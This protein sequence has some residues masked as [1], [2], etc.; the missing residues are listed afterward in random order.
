MIQSGDINFGV[1]NTFETDLNLPGERREGGEV[2]TL[3]NIFFIINHQIEPKK[4]KKYV[5]AGNHHAE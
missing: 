5:R 1:K 3:G 2:P 4:C